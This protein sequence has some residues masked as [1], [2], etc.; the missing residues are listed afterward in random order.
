MRKKKSRLDIKKQLMAAISMLLISSLMMVTSTY[1]WFTLSTAPEVKGIQTSVGANGNLEI[2]LLSTAASIDGTGITSAVGDSSAATGKSAL[3]ANITWGN[4]VDLSHDSYGLNMIKL[5]PAALDDGDNN[6]LV[7][8]G[9]ITHN[10]LAVPTY[11][12][13][14]RVNE[15]TAKGTQSG[16]YDTN[17]QAFIVPL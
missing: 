16:L 15:L 6:P 4:L 3:T 8:S 2:A 7:N 11:G 9:Y 17:K 1:A 14:G 12:A 13:D 5:L 10:F